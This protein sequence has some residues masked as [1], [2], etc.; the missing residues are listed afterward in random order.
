MQLDSGPTDTGTGAPKKQR[1][2][3]SHAPASTSPGQLAS[4]AHDP[5]PS[6]PGAPLRHRRPG[7]APRVQSA[8]PDPGS[9]PSVSATPVRETPFTPSTDLPPSGIAVP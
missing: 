9:G 5:I 2:S 3:T 8:D 6:V 1:A 7:P 4:V